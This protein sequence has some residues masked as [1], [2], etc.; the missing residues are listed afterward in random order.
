MRNLIGLG[1]A[2]VAGVLAASASAGGTDGWEGRSVVGWGNNGYGD[3]MVLTRGNAPAPIVVLLRIE[4]CTVPT[5]RS[6]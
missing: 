4:S 6:S 5:G 2:A 3:A 1:A